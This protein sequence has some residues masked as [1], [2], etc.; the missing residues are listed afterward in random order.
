MII[1]LI[2]PII[3]MVVFHKFFRVVYFGFKGMVV[4]YLIFY[5]IGMV[6]FGSIIG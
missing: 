5:I 4:E 6:I 3:M 1:L 2:L